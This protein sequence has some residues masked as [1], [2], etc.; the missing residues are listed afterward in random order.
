MIHLIRIYIYPRNKCKNA[1]I[2]G[3]FN[4]NEQDRSHALF[5]VEHDF[6]ITLGPVL[7]EIRCS[8]AVLTYD[9]L[10]HIRLVCAIH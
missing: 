6:F 1:F 3:H 5:I 2:F 10:I 7:Y 9:K 8:F 4:I